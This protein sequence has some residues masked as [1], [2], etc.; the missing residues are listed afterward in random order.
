MNTSE[1]QKIY[2]LLK[3]FSESTSSLNS[4]ANASTKHDIETI[5]EL[6]SSAKTYAFL[7]KTYV[8]DLKAHGEDAEK[9]ELVVSGLFYL[10][11][12]LDKVKSID[13]LS[14]N[15]VIAL[16]QYVSDQAYLTRRLFKEYILQ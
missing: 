15:E 9:V 8:G 12:Y 4:V 6:A 13:M 16:L 14:H 3:V 10:R 7:I 5:E 11:D 1:T 2:S